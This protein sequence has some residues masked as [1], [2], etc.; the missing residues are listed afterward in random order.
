MMCSSVY[1][2]DILNFLQDP[3]G[4]STQPPE[5]HRESCRSGA[6]AE[7][8]QVQVCAEGVGVPRSYRVSRRAQT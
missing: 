1:I 7:A 5:G 4:T 6:K 2:D 3:R 8:I